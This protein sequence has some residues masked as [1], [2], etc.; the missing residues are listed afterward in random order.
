MHSFHSNYHQ[1]QWDHLWDNQGVSVEIY[2]EFGTEKKNYESLLF[3][4]VAYCL[5]L[6][7]LDCVGL[8]D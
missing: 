1:L 3:S 6:R 7:L 8:Y 5:I 2:M 4:L